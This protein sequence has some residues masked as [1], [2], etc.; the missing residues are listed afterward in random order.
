MEIFNGW[1][2]RLL[3]SWWRD[4]MVEVV[5]YYSLVGRFNGWG[6]RSDLM[7]GVVGCYSPGEGILWLVS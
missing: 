4:V 2:C 1:G 7:A 6:C 5:S 3:F